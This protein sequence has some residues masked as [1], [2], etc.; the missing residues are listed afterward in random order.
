ML[1]RHGLRYH[2]APLHRQVA[3]AWHKVIRLS[4]PNGQWE[5]TR[6]RVGRWFR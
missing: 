4:L 2:A 5:R 3:S 1:E 6:H